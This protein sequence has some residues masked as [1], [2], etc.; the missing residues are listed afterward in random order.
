MSVVPD[1]VRGIMRQARNNPAQEAA[2]RTRHLNMWLG[3]DEALFSMRSWNA[4]AD[5]DLQLHQLEGRECHIAIDL[6]SKTDLAAVVI[7]FPEP[8][9]H[10]TAFA[11]CYLNEAAVMEARNPSYAGWAADGW[12]TITPGNETDFGTIEG[13]L[14][15]LFKIVR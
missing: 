2:A 11:R 10:Y 12:L 8:D 3:A 1:A 15:D 9:G 6:A 14:H 13:S 4:C 7:V 5:R